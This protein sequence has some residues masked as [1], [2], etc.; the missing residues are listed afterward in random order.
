MG[1]KISPGFIQGITF[2]KQYLSNGTASYNDYL[3][4]ARRCHNLSNKKE[5]L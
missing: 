5:S 2:K 4:A 3:S 1:N